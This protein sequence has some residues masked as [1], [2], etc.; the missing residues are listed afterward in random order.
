MKK[1]LNK[2]FIHTSIVLTAVLCL[3]ISSAREI[4]PER[5]AAE[6]LMTV[7]T[8]MHADKLCEVWEEKKGDYRMG[9]C[10]ISA[11]QMIINQA[12]FESIQQ[13][14]AGLQLLISF[15]R[16]YH[17][18]GM[19]PVLNQSKY[20]TLEERFKYLNKIDGFGK[21]KTDYHSDLT[22][23]LGADLLGALKWAESRYTDF[24]CDTGKGISP[25]RRKNTLFNFDKCLDIKND[26]SDEL[27][28]V[29][30]T[31][32][33]GIA[34]PFQLSRRKTT[35]KFVASPLT[36]VLK[37]VQELKSL[38]PTKY[39][40]CGQPIAFK[41]KTLGGMFPEEDADEIVSALT[42]CKKKPKEES[43]D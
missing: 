6:K 20:K 24:V 10:P 19:A 3:E 8:F 36:P 40:K 26:I 43:N 12:D 5:I 1:G 21:L 31:M 37:P 25:V 34:Q 28:V 18:D 33:N 2:L 15:I 41:D 29:L 9:V 7:H 23:T 11:K 35:K 16:S 38:F 22:K 14:F 39:D 42:I 13:I 17:I 4:Y 32:L 30:E 27:F